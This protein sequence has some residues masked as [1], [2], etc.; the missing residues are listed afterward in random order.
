MHGLIGFHDAWVPALAPLKS[1]LLDQ[2][3]RFTPAIAWVVCKVKFA[4]SLHM[5]LASTD[6]FQADDITNETAGSMLPVA[7]VAHML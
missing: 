3:A 1:R 4:P 7:L 6:A 2:S 5:L